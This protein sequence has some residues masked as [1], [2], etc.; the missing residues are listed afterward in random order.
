MKTF[1][2][3]IWRLYIYLLF[4]IFLLNIGISYAYVSY[5]NL[6]VLR[7]GTTTVHLPLVSVFVYFLAI[8]T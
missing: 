2:G 8:R 6:P 4:C 5:Y 3:L 7:M 1:Q